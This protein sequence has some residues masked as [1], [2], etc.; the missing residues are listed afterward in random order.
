MAIFLEKKNRN[1]I[2]NWRSF[3]N[4]VKLGELDGKIS[5]DIIRNVKPDITDL[6][7]DWELHKTIGVAADIIGVALFSRQRNHKTV[8]EIANFIIQNSDKSTHAM[9]NTA[10][11][12]LNTNAKTENSIIEYNTFEDF[13]DELKLNFHFVKISQ[14]KKALIR[15][16]NNPIAWVELSRLYTIVGNIIKAK[17]AMLNAL[18]LS[19]NNRFVLRSMIRFFVH[20]GE[21]DFAYKFLTK[22]EGIKSDPWLITNEISLSTI[23]GKGSKLAKSSV[24][25]V[26]NKNIHP[27]HLSELNSSLA[28]LE[29]QNGKVRQSKKMLKNSLINPND[30]ALAQ[31]A[32]FGQADRTFNIIDSSQFKLKSQFEAQARS[33][34]KL[35]NW[36][37]AIKDSINWFLD[38]PFSRAPIAMGNNIASAKLDDQ[39]LAVEIA[40]AGLTSQPNDLHLLNNIIYSLCLENRILDAKKYFERVRNSKSEPRKELKIC[41][42]ATEGLLEFRQ[43][44][45]E[46]GRKLYSEAISQSSKIKD[47]YLATSAFINYCREELL[48]S[49]I[50]Q[51]EIISRLNEIKKNS[52]SE[53]LS[54]AAEKV[55]NIVK[56]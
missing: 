25:I 33:N 32:W 26:N 20:I 42:M 13:K 31:A 5:T 10:N 16:P 39:N 9:I 24:K 2:P 46:N 54:E 48:L 52:K 23:L 30:N 22:S 41:L 44:N 51:P 6:I 12:L 55:I 17:R 14:I 21:I 56:I 47:D 34:F 40:K 11:E 53:N 4:T 50:H 38:M 7:N 27:F 45:V 36:N 19:P 1:V 37:E 8:T 3:R 29:F 35:K 15:N 18:F 28:T 49:K 43:G